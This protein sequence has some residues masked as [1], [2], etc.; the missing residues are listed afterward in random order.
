MN[1]KPGKYL[2]ISREGCFWIHDGYDIVEIIS[3]N[4]DYVEYRYEGDTHERRRTYW[5]FKEI[6][7]VPVN[8]LT[9][10]LI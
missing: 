5:E 3:V 9:R 1:L 2:I 10:E 4:E 8:A 7:I 6:S